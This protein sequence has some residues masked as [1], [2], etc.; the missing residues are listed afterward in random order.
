[1]NVDRGTGEV[2][3]DERH[4]VVQINA[5]VPKIVWPFMAKNDVRLY[6]NGLNL[7]PLGDDGAMIVASDGRRVV[8]VR[9]PDGFVGR[10][11]TVSFHKDGLK[12]CTDRHQF[13]VMSDGTSW[14]QDE[15]GA[16][17]FI[18]PGNV[19]I[20][21]DYP[22][23]E[24]V[25]RFDGYREGIFGD[26]NPVYLREAVQIQ[27]GSESQAIRFWSR[28]DNESPL[29]FTIDQVNGIE[30]CGAIA[31]MRQTAGALPSWIPEPDPFSL[32]ADAT[33]KWSR[34]SASVDGDRPVNTVGDNDQR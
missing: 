8:V 12:H 25:L 33:I 2:L 27:S 31:K 20:D 23:V 1:M 16:P 4:M 9:D 17:L 13:V 14:I 5:L 15:A 26:V 24:H 6:M 21:G 30:T 19:R 7:R 29:L 28:P 10:E 3:G 32:T 18:Q 11:L 34:R 22:R